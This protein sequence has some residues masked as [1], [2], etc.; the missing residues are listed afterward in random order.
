MKKFARRTFRMSH[1]TSK[2]CVNSSFSFIR[3]RR[4]RANISTCVSVIADDSLSQA[5]S[6]VTGLCSTNK[7]KISFQIEFMCAVVLSLSFEKDA[8]ERISVL[9]WMW[10]LTFL[11]QAESDVTD[12]D[13]TNNSNISC[14]IEFVCAVVFFLS[15]ERG[16]QDRIAVRVWMW[17]LASLFQ[18][19]SDESDVCSTN[20]QN[21]SSQIEFVCVL[22]FPFYSDEKYEAERIEVRVRWWEA[23]F[24]IESDVAILCVTN[25]S[26]S[27]F[28]IKWRKS[29]WLTWIRRLRSNSCMCYSLFFIQLLFDAENDVLDF[30]SENNSNTSSQI[31]FVCVLFFLFHSDEKCEVERIEV[32]IEWWIFSFNTE[33]DIANLCIHF[34]C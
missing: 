23:L 22:F 19:K 9:V 5:E 7:S 2:W 16:A 18:T 20:N 6:G 25:N 30:F 33:S 3:K 12:L 11:S 4:A 28:Q 21:I 8:Q 29:C 27:S 17:S 31:V 10:S 13:S 24:D 26:N 34:L 15:F 14:Q 1:V 32:W